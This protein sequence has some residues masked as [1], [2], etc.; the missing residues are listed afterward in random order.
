MK[1]GVAYIPKDG[2]LGLSKI[3][4]IADLCGKRLQLQ[5]RLGEDIAECM[6]IATGA[7]DIMVVIEGEHSC[8]TTRGISKPG[9]LTRTATLKGAFKTDSDLRSEAYRLLN[10]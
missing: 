4:R 8:M 7:D 2:V 6:E 10:M 3:A 9:T 5:E 1:V